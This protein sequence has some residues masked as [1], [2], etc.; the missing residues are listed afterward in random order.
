[1]STLPTLLMGYGTLFTSP[2]ASQKRRVQTSRN[3]LYIIPVAVARSSSDDSAICCVGLLSVSRM[4]S[5]LA[6]IDEAR[7]YTQS[8]SPEGST[9]SIPPLIGLR[10]MQSDA[11]GGRTGGDPDRHQNLIICSLAHCEPFLKISCKSIQ[12]FLCK[13]AN[14]QIHK[15][16]RL[17]ILLGGGNK[18]KK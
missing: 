9:V 14:R 2:C 3:F 4:T 18:K 6:I 13:V 11:A 15:Q 16:R 5:C 1:M 7:A 10:C 17:H 12:K 8:D